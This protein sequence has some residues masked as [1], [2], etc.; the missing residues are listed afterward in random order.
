MSQPPNPAN[1]YFMLEE[2][3]AD[4]T[5]DLGLDHVN[6]APTSDQSLYSLMGYV[7]TP[8]P[9]PGMPSSSWAGTGA[10]V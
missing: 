5:I 10:P 6:P 1:M 8:Y 7:P 3:L 4:P 9:L 2:G